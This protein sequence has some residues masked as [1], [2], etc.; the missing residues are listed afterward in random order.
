[1]KI[2]EYDG[3]NFFLRNRGVYT[4]IIHTLFHCCIY[5]VLTCP[6]FNVETV[7]YLEVKVFEPNK[8]WLFIGGKNPI[9][10]SSSKVWAKI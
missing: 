3:R 1:M 6:G 9:I 2:I 10:F 5:L 4:I 7:H 8:T